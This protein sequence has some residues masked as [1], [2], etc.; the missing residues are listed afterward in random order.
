MSEGFLSI[1]ALSVGWVTVHCLSLRRDIRKEKLF[2]IQ[3]VIDEIYFIEKQAV[4]FHSRKKFDPAE[5]QE[6]STRIQRLFKKLSA[7]PFRDFVISNQLKIEFRSAITL[8]NFDKSDF[9]AQKPD[10]EIITEIR[11]VVSDLIGTIEIKTQIYISD[12]IF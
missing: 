9:L 6:I 2:E 3:K 5:R 7:P 8:N 1:I 10:S 12:S 11:E 4:K